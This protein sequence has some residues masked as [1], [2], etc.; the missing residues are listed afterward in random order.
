MILDTRSTTAANASLAG[1]QESKYELG[2]EGALMH[3]YESECNYNAII[4]SVGISELKY[5]QET[6]KDLFVNEAGAFKGFLGKVKAFFQ[7]VIEKIKS[8]FKKFA[9]TMNKYLLSDKDFEKKYR[10][11]VLD[12][13]SG[14][15]D[16]EVK[17]YTFD[18]LDDFIKS[19]KNKVGSVYQMQLGKINKIGTDGGADTYTSKG[20]LDADGIETAKDTTRGSILGGEACDV[21]D[22]RK[23]LKNKCYGNDGEKEDIK[24]DSAYMAA[25][26]DRLKTAKSDIDNANEAQKKLTDEISKVI[27]ALDGLGDKFDKNHKDDDKAD[28][29]SNA[30]AKSKQTKAVNNTIDILKAASNDYTTAFGTAVGALKDRNRQAKAFAVKALSYKA[31]EEAASYS[32]SSVDDIFASVVIR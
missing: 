11:Q 18:G 32:E 25:A 9:A 5:Y 29:L 20:D 15:K 28:E 14:A 2:L 16:F 23:E 21:E 17:G 19:L 8:I 7:A 13:L 1:V 10:K 3:V 24:V 22:F 4:K 31:Q 30:E 27:K 12:K 26:F 6:G